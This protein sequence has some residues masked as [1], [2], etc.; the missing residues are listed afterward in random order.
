MNRYSAEIG[1]EITRDIEKWT[2]ENVKKIETEAKKIQKQ[3]KKKLEE[4][5]PIRNYP[6]NGG[7]VMKIVVSRRKNAKAIKEPAEHQPGTFKKTG[8]SSVTLK[9]KFARN[10]S[11][12]FTY[13]VRKKVFPTL[14]H[15]LN[16]DH[17]VVAHGER[18]GVVVHGSRFVSDVQEWG[19]KELEKKIKEIFEK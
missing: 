5:T 15:L 3:M 7:T 9:E 19:R 6:Y 1:N 14:V 17:D 11:V 13:G 10:N 18:T 16:F 12:Q 4:A 2:T 8:W